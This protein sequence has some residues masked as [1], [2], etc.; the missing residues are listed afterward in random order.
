M[1]GTHQMEQLTMNRIERAGACGF[2]TAAPARLQTTRPGG[3]AETL[4]AGTV[5][6]IKVAPRAHPG[7]DPYQSAFTAALA[8]IAG[9]A[10]EQGR[11]P[12]LAEAP[13]DGKPVSLQLTGFQGGRCGDDRSNNPTT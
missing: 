9:R 7:R 2:Q 13:R 10:V 1:I 6:P 11:A 5:P 12:A 8:R 4:A 3:S